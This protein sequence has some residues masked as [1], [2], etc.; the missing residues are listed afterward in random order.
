ML[1]SKIEEINYKK[2]LK[3]IYDEWRSLRADYKA[4]IILILSILVLG[5]LLPTLAY[6]DVPYGTDVFTHLIYTKIMIKTSSL[7]RFYKYCIQHYYKEYGYP[8][9]MWFFGAIVAKIAGLKPLELAMIFPFFVMII[10]LAL[11]YNFSKL[12]VSEV[13]DSNRVALLSIL[14]LIT[15]PSFCMSLLNYSTSIFT[16]FSVIFLLYVI[17]NDKFGIIEKVLMVSLTL[18]FLLITHTGT[19]MFLIFLFTAM[20]F[21]Y[22]IF[23]NKVNYVVFLA[24]TIQ[25][26]YMVAFLG[27]IFGH[28]HH[29]YIDKGRI[30][31]SVGALLSSTTKL[32]IFKSFSELIYKGI[33]LNL[34]PIIVV[35][36]LS[37]VYTITLALARLSGNLK[38]K[39][40]G[41]E[42]S[43]A[44]FGITHISHEVIFW[45]LWL[46]PIHVAFSIPGFLKSNKKGKILLLSIALVAIPTGLIAKERALRE[47]HY[48]YII[49]PIISAIGFDYLYGWVRSR[50]ES[51]SETKRGI[52]VLATVCILTSLVIIPV[53]GN[54]Y[55]HPMISGPKYERDGLKWLGSIGNSNE[56]AAGLVGSRV[57]IYSDKVPIAVTSVSAGSEAKR[58]GRDLYNILFTRNSEKYAK[59]LYTAFGVKYYILTSKIERVYSLPMSAVRIDENTQLDKIYS[60]EN[61]FGIYSE[62][63]YP[64]ERKSVESRI[65]FENVPTIKDTG[66]GY[67]VETKYYKIRIGKEN[68]GIEYLGNRTFDFLG[69]GELFDIVTISD[70]KENVTDAW[71]L[72]DQPYSYIMLGKN[73]IVYKTTLREKG[74]PVATLIVKYTFYNESFRRDIVL[75]SDW[76]NGSIDSSYQ[77]QFFTPMNKFEIYLNNYKLKSRIVYPSEDLVVMKNLKFNGFLL[78]GDGRDVFIYYENSAPY[79]VEVTYKGSTT[80]LYKYYSVA[81][82][83]KKYLSP[84]ET[85]HVTQIIALGKD[86]MKKAEKYDVEIAQY[87]YGKVPVILVCEGGNLNVTCVHVPVWLKYRLD[88]L[89]RVRGYIIGKKIRLPYFVYNKEG[90]RRV[91]ELYYHGEK[92]NVVLLPISK[93]IIN[94]YTKDW[95]KA[96]DVLKSA[97]KNGDIVVFLWDLYK[98]NRSD[99]NKIINYIKENKVFVLTTPEDVVNYTKSLRNVRVYV[100]NIGSEKRV[101]IINHNDFPVKGFTLVILG[102]RGIE[103]GK[104]DR[105]VN[106]KAYVSVDLSPHG[107]RTITAY[108]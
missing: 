30:M 8:F 27:G 75:A 33:F 5:F 103:G 45:P 61:H 96:I 98:V 97:M 58:F 39:I 41:I 38:N 43:P 77:M 16:M 95:G 9:G 7:S 73:K 92:L 72:Q 93:P 60:T 40:R 90:F 32:P 47:L 69:G 76:L 56:G 81:M 63:A 94:E 91:Q 106:G 31:L 3:N 71:I 108:S 62:I 83:L 2:I 48:F 35:L 51:W 88:E 99:L 101:T 20:L 64:T 65:E 86:A 100:T 37:L 50:Y 80:Y 36:W 12:F 107:I 18:L 105:I 10:L 55:Y 15:T 68:P 6:S 29:Q 85:L 21:I 89:L 11:Y 79:P 42:I 57:A 59:D 49:L 66:T 53:V 25:M 54:L 1:K 82:K 104:L 87:R 84:G 22:S 34:N 52:V 24:L 17:L 14:M 46:G 28:V 78:H 74:R 4:L 19:Y 67:L 26:F 44:L 13:S 23:E 102:C 70:P